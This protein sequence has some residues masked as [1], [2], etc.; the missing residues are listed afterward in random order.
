MSENHVIGSDR[1]QKLLLPD[2]LDEYVNEDSDARFI[3]AFVDRLDLHGFGFKHSAPKDG[4]GRPSYSPYDLLKLYIYGY[5]NQVRSS[6]KLERECRR[7]LEA[8]WLI[9]KLTPDF[10]TIANFRKDNV[11]CIKKVFRE[12]VSI[13][14]GLDLIGGELVGID[15][16]KLKAVNS[17]NRNFNEGK[18][19]YRLERL[20]RHTLEYLREIEE[21]DRKEPDDHDEAQKQR[22]AF[23]VERAK[24]EVEKL[25]T[26]KNEYD[27]LLDL[28]HRTGQTEI[29]L[30]DPES[31]LMKNNEKLEV[32]YNVQSIVDSKHH[33]VPE[34]EVTNEATDRE[35]LSLMAKSAKEALDVERLDVTADMGYFSFQRIKECIDDG[36]TPYVSELP[37]DSR[38]RNPNGTQDPDFYKGKFHYDKER[39]SYT[40]PAGNE[41]TLTRWNTRKNGMRLKVYRTPA[42]ADCRFRSMCTRDQTNGRAVLRWEHEDVI[43]ELRAMLKTPEG[44]AIV[45]K[46]RE[47]VEHPFGTIKRA[48][49]QGYLLLKGLRKVRGEVGFTMLAYNMRRAIN[50]LGT[51]RLIDSLG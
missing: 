26:K 45:K 13:C 38:S 16:T 36:I 1:G 33:L 22:Q 8:M 3:D 37:L 46:R 21:N 11:D 25:E 15:G 19:K 27:G 24:K 4:A 48:F 30:T 12:F 51:K 49:N 6:R 10:K 2:T 29:S 5:L 39:D 32:C 44:A 35:Q 42:C 20:E 28:L 17:K 50:I 18:L 23:V 43:E 41:L 34:Y 40:C 31:R 47:L 9:R 14:K 7:N